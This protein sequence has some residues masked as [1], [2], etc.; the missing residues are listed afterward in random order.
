MCREDENGCWIWGGSTRGDGYGQVSRP[1]GSQ[2]YAHI[3]AYE[4]WK[5]PVPE[6]KIVMH[7]CDVKRCAR[8]GH[9]VAGTFS[10]NSKDMMKKGRGALNRPGHRYVT[11]P[12]R[13]ALAEK[14]IDPRW[15]EQFCERV[16]KGINK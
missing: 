4:L 5:G 16:R 9:L 6:G 15:R 1:D 11:A 14:F 10:E 12:A 8:P 3:R 13:A 2:T 7:R